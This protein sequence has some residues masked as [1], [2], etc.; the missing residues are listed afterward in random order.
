MS[1]LQSRGEIHFP[2]K[3]YNLKKMIRKEREKTLVHTA[4]LVKF[5]DMARQKTFVLSGL[6]CKLVLGAR[7]VPRDV[8]ENLF[9]ENS[10]SMN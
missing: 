10:I 8:L 2:R 9:I 5:P 6:S 3:H 7:Y 1:N 4:S